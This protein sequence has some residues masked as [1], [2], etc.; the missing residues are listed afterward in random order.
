MEP[1]GLGSV[2]RPIGLGL[3]GFLVK[4]PGQTHLY[5]VE[6]NLKT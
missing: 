5:L 6:I 2:F 4:S 1:F 3:G